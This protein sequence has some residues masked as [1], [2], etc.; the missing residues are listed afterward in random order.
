GAN[1]GIGLAFV[2]TLKG[3]GWSTIGSVR[4]ET[5]DDVSV[6]ELSAT[7]SR[8]VKIDYKKEETI[9]QAAKELEDVKIDLLINCAGIAVQPPP[10]QDHFKVDLMERFEVMTVGPFLAIKHFFP[11][12]LRDGGG[13]IV[14][15]SSSSGSIADQLTVTLANDFKKNGHPI[16]IV[17]FQPGYIKTKLTG[18]KGPI[19]ID[20]S[21][22]GM[23]N[24]TE[25]IT[26]EG[27]PY[28]LSWKGETIPW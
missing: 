27:S 22:S 16:G 3:R 15:M 28:F 19:D 18:F 24:L 7:G 8:I 2:R 5:R 10:W 23:A 1:R 12:I 14:N 13:T 20:E 17:A 26:P 9:V 25:T 11:H 6:D 4:P 21:V